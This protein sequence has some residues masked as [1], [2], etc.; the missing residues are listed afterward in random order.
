MT[1]PYGFRGLA[2]ICVRTKD[3][4]QSL[5]FYTGTLGF[6]VDFRTVLGTDEEPNGFW[7]LKYALVRQGSC[8]VELLEPSDTGRVPIA[9]KGSVEHFALLVDDLAAAVADL[10]NRG[11][12]FEG[13]IS[14]VP[15]LPG[16]FQSIFLNGP[17]GESIELCEISGAG[18][19][20]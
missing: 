10:Q 2:H 16:A 6:A 15:G 17:S 11:V 12:A 9:I 18:V 5:A 14:S 13:R 3:I 19:S 7:P 8:A 20:Q 1:K 4:E